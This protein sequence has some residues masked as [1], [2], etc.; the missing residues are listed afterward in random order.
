MINLILPQVGLFSMVCHVGGAI[1]LAFVLLE[2]LPVLALWYCFAFTC[3]LPTMIELMWVIIL[4]RMQGG[5]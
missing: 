2:G 5:R 4:C 1:G 3:A